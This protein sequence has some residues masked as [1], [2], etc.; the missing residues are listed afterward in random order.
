MN[1]QFQVQGRYGRFLS[2]TFIMMP[3]NVYVY[4]GIW[5]GMAVESHIVIIPCWLD[6]WQALD[7]H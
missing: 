7:L 3:A 4:V 2:T 1:T 5:L 6:W